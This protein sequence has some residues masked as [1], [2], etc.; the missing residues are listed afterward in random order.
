MSIV[1][2]TKVGIAN[3]GSGVE[4]LRRSAK[5]DSLRPR[6]HDHEEVTLV[7]DVSASMAGNVRKSSGWGSYG[8][9]V[10]GGPRRIDALYDASLAFIRAC[11]PRSKVGAIAFDDRA[12]ILAPPTFTHGAVAADLGRLGLGG[13]TDF[14]VGIQAAIGLLTSPPSGAEP[15]SLKRIVLMT[16][17]D[18]RPRDRNALPRVIQHAVELGIIIDCVSFGGASQSTLSDIAARTGGVVKNASNAD[19]LVKAFKQL[20]A[21]A[22]GLLG[23]GK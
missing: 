14:A 3:K 15:A 7:L 21:G 20:E 12:E 13:G 22:R 16:D 5:A 10:A 11:S 1:K 18:D 2:K 19:E 23:K 6:M 8:E 9:V 17:G 4:A